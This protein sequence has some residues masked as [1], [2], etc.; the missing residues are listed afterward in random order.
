[1]AHGLIQQL[2]VDFSLAYPIKQGFCCAVCV[3]QFRIHTGR[4]CLRDRIRFVF[5]EMVVA[6]QLRN[7]EVVGYDDA[8]KIPLVTQRVAQQRF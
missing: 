5:D 2:H 6:V 8:V 1:M 4:K 3:G 7:G